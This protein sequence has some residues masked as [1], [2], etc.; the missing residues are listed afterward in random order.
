MHHTERMKAVA[1]LAAPDE[2]RPASLG[3]IKT[4]AEDIIFAVKIL[5]DYIGCN[6]PTR[7]HRLTGYLQTIACIQKGPWANGSAWIGNNHAVAFICGQHAVRQ[8]NALTRISK[9]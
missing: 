7:D 2:Q 8:M 6:P 5:I 3:K 9:K 4:G 1:G